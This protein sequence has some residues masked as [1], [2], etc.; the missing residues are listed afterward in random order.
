MKQYMIGGQ[1]FRTQKD[2]VAHVQTI[3]SRYRDGE[4]LDMF[5]TA[6]MT[7]LLRSHPEASQKFGCGLAVVFVAE[8]PMY[9]GKRNRG[10]WLRRIDGSTTDFSYRECINATSHDKKVLRAMR[11]A[12]EPDTLAFKQA[13]FDNAPSGLL[14]CPDTDELLTFTTAHVDHKAP[15][16]FDVLAREFLKQEGLDFSDI[17]IVESKDNEYQDYLVSNELKRRWVTFH[18][19]HAELEIVSKT[20]NLSLRKRRS[21]T[22]RQIDPDEVT[23]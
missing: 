5:D 8:N 15:K 11:A 17:A 19:S 14:R 18:N 12:V 22:A 1:T 9:P 6:F 3:L 20:S 7:D 2:L 23:P 16:T 10:F 13:A 4:T 21:D